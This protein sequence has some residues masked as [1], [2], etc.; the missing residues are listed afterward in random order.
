MKTNIYTK[1]LAALCA[2]SA[3]FA[4][5]RKEVPVQ[6]EPVVK[7]SYESLTGLVPNGRVTASPE[8]TSGEP[9]DFSISS[10]FFGEF[11]YKGG[12]F[13]I[14]SETGEIAVTPAADAAEGE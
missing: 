5:C 6:E 8:I 14:D 13:S 12:M 10:V 4:G 11:A 3:I 9:T 7:L 2:A 1:A